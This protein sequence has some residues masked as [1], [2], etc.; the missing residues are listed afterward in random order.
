MR[1]LVRRPPLTIEVMAK[2]ARQDIGKSDDPATWA[3]RLKKLR[4]FMRYVQQFEPL[5]EVPDD[6]IFGQ[7]GQ[8]LAPHIYSEQEITDLMTAARGLGPTEVMPKQSDVQVAAKKAP[9]KKINPAV[10]A[11]AAAPA[12]TQPADSEPAAATPEQSPATPTS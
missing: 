6:R 9:V 7:S 1:A 8:R 4:S 11:K 10:K 3:R 5:T 12:Q 2:W